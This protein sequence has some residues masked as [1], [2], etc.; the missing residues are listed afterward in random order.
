MGASTP[1]RAAQKRNEELDRYINLK[2]AALGQPANRSTAGD[3]LLEIAWPLL[4]NYRQKSQVLGTS[5]CP[6]DTRIQKFLD[7]Y[8]ADVCPRGM[9]RL[10]PDALVLDRAGMGRVLSLPVNSDT[11]GSRYLRSYRLAQ[12]VLHNPSSDRRT[13]QGLFHIC[14]GGFPVP[15]DKSVV[16]KRAFA[17]LWKAALQPPADLLKLPFTSGEEDEAQCFVSLLLRPLVCPAAGNDPAKSME[18]RFFAPASLVSNLDFVESIFGNGGDPYLPEN[19]AALDPM[20]WTG[21][22]GCVLLAPHLVGIRK[23][24][25]GLPHV[26]GASE[27]ER[28]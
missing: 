26:S 25:L 22:S 3:D 12:G 6:A 11:F 9:P 23:I 17:A 5:L 1:T 7:D 15:A 4:R 14:D 18:V 21:Q 8:F 19:D 27:R 28:R 13:T 16:A 10:P 20:H 2:L 24:E